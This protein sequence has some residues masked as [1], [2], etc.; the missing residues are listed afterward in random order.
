MN[1]SETKEQVHELKKV[2]SATPGKLYITEDFNTHIGSNVKKQKE[3]TATGKT[4]KLN[5]YSIHLRW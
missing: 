5:I 2:N 4:G 1:T 3:I